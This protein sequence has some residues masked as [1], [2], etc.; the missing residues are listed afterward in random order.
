MVLGERA[1]KVDGERAY[2]LARANGA[3]V[4]LKDLGLRA[5][6]LEVACDLALQKQY[7]NPRPL[8]RE[9]LMALLRNAYE[10]VRPAA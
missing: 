1:V 9:P 7:P 8:E 4:A 3:P 6:D 10:G 2:D 5:A